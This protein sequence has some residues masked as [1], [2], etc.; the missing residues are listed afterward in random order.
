MISRRR[1]LTGVAIGLAPIGAPAHAQEYKAQQAGKVDRVGVVL[2]GGPYY[3]AIDG[4]RAG[5]KEVGFEEGK[6]YLLN[7]QDVKGDL[8]AILDAARNLEQERVDLIFAVGTAT[9]IAERRATT[10]APVVFYAGTDP[11][12]IRLVKSFA[13]PGGRLTGVHSRATDLVAKRLEILKEIIPKLRHVLTF[14]DPGN[15]G[16][17]E[18]APLA[19]EA[20]KHLGSGSSSGM[21]AR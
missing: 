20:A 16:P 2:E 3:T 8:K 17:R 9:T 19:R 12:G 1:F 6:Q 10:T 4:L 7:I 21:S 13:R 11:V 18:S 5:L 15:P 14:Y